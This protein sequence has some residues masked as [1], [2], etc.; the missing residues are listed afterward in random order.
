MVISPIPFNGTNKCLVASYLAATVVLWHGT[1]TSQSALL[2]YGAVCL[3]GKKRPFSRLSFLNLV[4]LGN[5]GNK[6]EPTKKTSWR[7]SLSHGTKRYAISS[8]FANNEFKEVVRA[9]WDCMSKFQSEQG[10]GMPWFEKWRTYHLKAIQNNSLPVR[11][12]VP[13]IVMNMDENLHVLP[14]MERNV[15]TQDG[16]VLSMLGNSILNHQ[17]VFSLVLQ[18]HDK[19]GI[20]DLAILCQLKDIKFS[21][22]GTHFAFFGVGRL[23]VDVL[24]PVEWGAKHGLRHNTGPS[25][26]LS[27]NLRLDEQRVENRPLAM[28]KAMEINEMYDSAIRWEAEV[29]DLS[30]FGERAR[31][32][33][34]GRPALQNLVD[35]ALNAIYTLPN[36]YDVWETISFLSMRFHFDIFSK[37][38]AMKLTVS[39]S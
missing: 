30:G 10:S 6:F 17:G 24:A 20:L 27:A 14:G 36:S 3:Q 9:R 39:V 35:N 22:F 12:W 18:D 25:L 29:M 31:R 2:R 8:S 21:E 33:I 5:K 13:S 4:P 19:G 23:D 37:H 7:F 34:G 15:T 32:L 1:C 11:R 26:E 28:Q 16:A 38:E